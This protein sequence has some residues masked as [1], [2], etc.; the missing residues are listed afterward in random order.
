MTRPNFSITIMGALAIGL[1]SAQSV[2]AQDRYIGEIITVG[3][4]FCPR[5]TIEASGAL[6][7]VSSNDALFSLVGTIYGGDGRTTFGMPDTRGRKLAGQGNGPG[8][9][10][11]T[12]EGQRYGA[13]TATMTVSQ[14][15]SHSH[16]VRANN[17]DGDKPGP[18]GKLLAAAPPSGVGSETIYSDMGPNRTMSSQMIASSGGG[19]SF[20]IQD[21]SIGLKFCV[22]SSGIYPSRN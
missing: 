7:A 22:V 9:G 6:L 19:A 15:P 3:F 17:L 10:L 18:G 13:T 16:E 20:P 21:P 5:G 11:S 8:V 4:N 12:R 1:A 14:M 2:H